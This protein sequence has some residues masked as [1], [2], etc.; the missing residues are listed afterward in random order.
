MSRQVRLWLNIARYG[1]YLFL[2]VSQ[3]IGPSRLPLDRLLLLGGLLLAL[4][5]A[6]YLL[7]DRALSRRVN[8]MLIATGIGLALAIGLIAPRSPFY[9]LYFVIL[10][11]ALFCFT[12]LLAA[13]LGLVGY[14][15]LAANFALIGVP[16]GRLIEVMGS[17][18]FGYMFIGATAYLAI[19]QRRAREKAELLLRELNAAHQR[20]QAYAV[21]VETLSVARERQRLAQEVHD[22]VAHVLTGLLVQVQAVRRT[23]QT[24]AAAAA[25]RLATIEEAARRGLDEVRRAV[26]AMRPEHLEGVGGV[27]AMRRLCDQFA[28]RTGIR[29]NLITDPDLRLSPV[30]E[31]LFY[32]TL[33]ECLTNSARHGRAST[34][35]ATLEGKDARALLRVRDDGIGVK[36]A[37]PGMGIGGMQ[38]RAQAAGG[39]FTYRNAA[40][41]G[42]E[43]L[44]ELPQSGLAAHTG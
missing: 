6:L 11:H 33:Q 36:D 39:R 12:P 42:F 7:T 5:A 31:V 9:M 37:Q 13:V 20:L 15:A 14:L 19:E 28:E 29:V 44:L 27:E 21:E 38:E 30:H 23:L 8:L 3:A 35:W 18:L 41:G 24:D 40:E 17:I 26:R 16:T 22:A 43:V 1:V 34:V 2:F 25:A 10:G 32:R 4:A